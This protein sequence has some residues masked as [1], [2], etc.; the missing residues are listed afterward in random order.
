ML[1]VIKAKYRETPVTF[2]SATL[3]E[4]MCEE[5]AQAMSK[6]VIFNEPT[7]RPNL[8]YEVR[9]MTAN[10]VLDEALPELLGQAHLKEKKGIV[11]CPYVKDCI[12]FAALLKGKGHRAEPYYGKM[13]G[14]DE[15][16]RAW[17]GEECDILVATASTA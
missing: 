1:G 10:P 6:P 3:S 12:R 9:N 16:Y 2:L 17:A 13:V 15:V 11:Y 5:L 14:R 7:V 8:Y 4:R